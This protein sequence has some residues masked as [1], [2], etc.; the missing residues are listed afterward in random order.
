[1]PPPNSISSERANGV[2]IK[3]EL[4]LKSKTITEWNPHIAAAIARM[5]RI[6]RNHHSNTTH[7]PQFVR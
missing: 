3:I 6:S 5:R 2:L 7:T 1:M 4:K